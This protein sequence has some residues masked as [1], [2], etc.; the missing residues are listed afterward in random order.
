M[1][2]WQLLLFHAPEAEADF[3]SWCIERE[4]AASKVVKQNYGTDKAAQ[5]NGESIAYEALRE[6]FVTEAREF[7]DQIER[8]RKEN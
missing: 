1:R 3:I 7:R 4:Q 5:A 2:T 6:S 8:E